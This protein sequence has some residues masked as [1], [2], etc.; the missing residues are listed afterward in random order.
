MGLEP[1]LRTSGAM[2]L[3][4]VLSGVECIND[5]SKWMHF[6]GTCWFPDT[7]GSMPS[8]LVVNKVAGHSYVHTN[9]AA[10]PADFLTNRDGNMSVRIRSGKVVLDS[11]RDMFYFPTKSLNFVE[12]EYRWVITYISLY[13]LYYNINLLINYAIF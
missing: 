6:P 12:L 1:A 5:F 9:G 11:I 8:Q 10:T 2:L 13:K 3:I 4:Y 7:K